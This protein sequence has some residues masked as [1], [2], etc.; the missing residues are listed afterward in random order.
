MKSINTLVLILVKFMF[1]CNSTTRVQRYSSSMHRAMD[2]D[3]LMIRHD[4]DYF[5]KIN[6]SNNVNFT[7]LFT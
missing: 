6:R 4:D 2:E 1:L 3:S 5:A 7:S